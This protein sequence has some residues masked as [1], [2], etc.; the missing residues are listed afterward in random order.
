[1]TSTTSAIDFATVEAI[2]GKLDRTL[3]YDEGTRLPLDPDAL[4]AA[5]DLVHDIPTPGTY[6]P[7]LYMLNPDTGN[8]SVAYED[9]LATVPLDAALTFA[10]AE[11]VAAAQGLRE[12]HRKYVWLTIEGRKAQA[13]EFDHDH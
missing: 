9:A 6:S 12:A 11:I 4:K 8:L 1:M 10:L 5:V 3:H 2:A 7:V 13:E